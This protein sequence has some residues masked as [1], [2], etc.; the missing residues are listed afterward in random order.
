MVP[1]FE[2][3]DE[4]WHFAFVQQVATGQ[5]LPVSEPNTQALWRQQGVQAPGYYLAAAAL[6]SWIDQTDFPS[7]YARINPH[8]A[9]GQPGAVTNRNFLIHHGDEEWPWRNTFLAL[10]VTRFFSIL[11][12]AVTLWA[13]F[14]AVAPI[15][16]SAWAVIGVAFFAFIP[17]YVFISAAATND[18]AVNALA[19]L[20]LWRVVVLVLREPPLYQPAALRRLRIDYLFMGVLLGLAALSKLS[21]LGL[22]GIAGL[23]V[24]WVSWRWRSIRPIWEAIVWIGVP[25]ALIAGW[26]YVR[27]YLLYSDFLAWN[28]WQQNILLRVNE[29]TWSIIAGELTS[30]ERSFWG[31]FGWLNIAYPDWVYLAFRI[32]GVRRDS[33]VACRT[34]QMATTQSSAGHAL[35][36]SDFAIAVAGYPC[37]FLAA[38]HAHC[39]CRTGPL[40]LPRST[41][42]DHAAGRQLQR[43]AHARS[44]LACCRRHVRAGYRHALLDHSTSLCTAG[45]P[46]R[47]ASTLSYISPLR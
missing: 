47:T 37:R 23:A 21:A 46:G 8:A 38:F 9:I 18:N 24:L 41:G 17:Q 1:A 12:G 11:L 5:G 26:W 32:A 28:V 42:T 13:S 34:D 3:P 29:A 33:R 7:I 20:A 16:G 14:Q 22:V 27:N 44:R 15:I 6:T 4:I 43:L 39:T 30:L 10:H 19:A 36:G 40:L 45:Q 31:L 25:A 35:V 2:T